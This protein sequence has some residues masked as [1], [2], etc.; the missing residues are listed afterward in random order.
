MR[1]GIAVLGSVLLAITGC[2]VGPDYKRPEAQVPLKWASTRPATTQPAATALWW[3][4]FKDPLLDSLIRRAVQG[5]LD[6]KTAEARIRAARASYGV[7]VARG[8]PLIDA[9]GS[10]SRQRE[11]ENRRNVGAHDVPEGSAFIAGLDAAWEIDVF[12]GVRRSAEAA[13]ATVEAEQENLQAVQVTL[14][15]EVALNYVDVRGFQR[16]IAIARQNVQV[17]E[18]TYDVSQ[19]RFAGGATG[20]LNVAR[21]KAQL[22]LTRAQ[23]PVLE[24]GLKAAVYRLGVLLGLEPGALYDELSAPA[25]IP[26]ASAE[27]TLGLPSDLLRR[28]PDIRKAE[29]ELAAANAGIGVLTA[30]LFPR[31]FLTGA[32]GTESAQLKDVLDAGS[33]TWAFGPEVRWRILESGRIRSAIKVQDA[34]TEQAL[35]NYRKVVLAAL[36]EV[37]NALASYYTE[38]QRRQTLAGA[39]GAAQR[40]S[41]V[42]YEMYANG[43]I[44]VLDVLDSQRTLYSAQD[45]LARSDQA[46]AVSLIT[47]YKALG[48]GWEVAPPAPEAATTRKASA[49]SQ[50]K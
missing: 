44:G 19:K 38:S 21:A 49:T 4:N 27:V 2:T 3:K 33:R 34:V 13:R 14:L 1:N 22:E 29:R 25:S 32:I 39:V 9:S 48:G 46:L 35:M 31:F 6:L 30:Q 5:N 42:S 16:R 24:R 20:E 17:Q 45:Q 15:A 11:S 10:Y 43:L 47:L 50:P 7:A 18:R 26:V 41:D 28:R 12:G 40:A 8:L 36:E 37:E 23:A